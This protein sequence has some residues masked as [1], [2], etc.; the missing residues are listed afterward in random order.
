MITELKYQVFYKENKK[1]T[2]QKRHY[3]I[4][5]AYWF[6]RRTRSR[7]PNI[8]WTPVHPFETYLKKN[9]AAGKSAGGGPEFA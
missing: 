4:L 5:L 2:T 6:S 9:S 1:N 8:P 3:Q 7:R